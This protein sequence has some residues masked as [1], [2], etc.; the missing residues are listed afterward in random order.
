[1][2]SERWRRI[3]KLLQAAL[4]RMPAERA[5]FLRQ[6]CAGDESLEREVLSLL[7]SQK[8][9][10]GFLDRPA[11]EVAAHGITVT[12]PAAPASPRVSLIG[13][14]ISHYR[15]VERLGS[16]G[17]GVVYKA[18][19]IRLHRFVALKFLPDEIASAPRVLGRFQREARAASAL[20]HPNI[21]TIYDVEEHEHQPMIVMELLDGES[22]KDKIRA[23]LPSLDELLHFA[24]QTSDALEAAH[25]KGIIHRDIKPAN[26]F[27]TRRGDAKIL[28]FGLAKLEEAPAN[29]N[30]ETATIQDPLTST[31]NTVGTVSYMSPEQ[32]RAENLDARTDLF[33]FGVVLYEM[34]TGKQPF[35]GDTSGI[36][37]DS[38]LNRA[39]VAPVRL[40]PDLPAEVERIVNK[41]LEKDR[42]LRYQHAADIR[43]DLN[44]LQRDS[45]TGHVI[46]AEVPIGSS[47]KVAR[48]ARWKPALIAAVAL[49][50]VAVTSYFYTHQA[51]KLTD[52]DTIVLAD[53]TNTTGDPV[54]DGTLRQGLSIQLA[55]SPFLSLISDERIQKV[56]GLMGKAPDARLTPQLAR[57][58]CERTASAAVLEGSL[59]AI[60][61]QFVLGLRAKS[62]RSGDILDEEQVQAAN[63][64]EV[65]NSL[66]KIASRFRTRVGESL[67]TIQ[68]HD[69]PLE[70]ATTPSLEALKAFSTAQKLHASAE[71]VR[72]FPLF[73]RAIEI[74]PTFALAYAN[75][76]QLYGEFGESDL[77]AENTSKAYSLRDRV[78]D[79]ER[80]FISVSYDFRQTGNLERARQTCELWVPTYPRD[81]MP[82]AFLSTIDAVMGRYREGL[83]EARK[84]MDLDPES[85]IGYGD[86]A[87]HSMNLDRYDDVENAMNAAAKRNLVDISFPTMRYTLA[88]LRGDE[89]A[90]LREVSLSQGRPGQEDF[91]EDQEA[92]TLAYFGR[93]RDSRNMARR[94]S[95]V[96]ELASQRESSALY[97]VGEAVREAFL[98]Y[99]TEAK[100]SAA[101]ALGH[102]KDREVVYGAAF[103]YALTR[104]V[105]RAQ[106]L[107]NDLQ[108]R[109]GED[110][111]VRANY[112]PVLHALFALNRSDPTNAVESLR[113]ALPYEMGTPR[114]T[115]HGFFG[116]LYPAYVRGQAYLALHRPSEAAAEFR[117]I[118]DHRGLVMSD[119]VAAMARLQF[120]RALADVDKVKA[121]AAYQDLFNLWKDADPDLPVLLQARAEGS[122][123]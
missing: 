36:I 9:A 46:S 108:N 18:E 120:A 90:R 94:A 21:C 103:A 39:P 23:G 114:S 79:L 62:C 99:N 13:Q 38:I 92:F 55:Q 122:R 84:I 2:E 15:I 65:L 41:C 56:L 74:D 89:A 105:G 48:P 19:D 91:V 26:L 43:S 113:I 104:D 58:I 82:H 8:E 97:E 95:E 61:S 44:R 116:V 59:S 12:G 98:G 107:A 28:D 86:V 1:M 88:F 57:E 17:M 63:K 22:V 47:N 42:N 10:D 37:F 70:E 24:I 118:L 66:S 69:T 112:M 30:G 35:R 102:S 20:N 117:K 53:F 34:A 54:F 40:N 52:K 16:G 49:S 93:V 111:S 67:A 14:T 45:L 64:E 7:A 27:V 33:S 6:A 87:M 80:L 101:T 76:G 5:T 81:I 72:A 121:K 29:P 109:F 60:G 73:K 51:P 78:S 123:L 85:A 31:G 100:A 115:I 96:A 119:P 106:T 11:I 110:T 83:D 68:K 71:S 4:E 25:A 75:L 3:D 50:A 32:V 77:A